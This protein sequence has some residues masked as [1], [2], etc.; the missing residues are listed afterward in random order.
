VST[1]TPEQVRARIAAQASVEPVAPVQAV[2]AP[3]V[4]SASGL[5]ERALAVAVGLAEGLSVRA[6]S[7]RSGIHRSSVGRISR[8][9]DVRQRAAAE[10]RLAG[11]PEPPSEPTEEERAEQVRAANAE[12][13]RKHR[14]R[15][16]SAEPEETT[17][18]TRGG[19]GGRVL[20]VI[21]DPWGDH[22]APQVIA[23]EREGPH[24]VRES[25]WRNAPREEQPVNATVVTPT[26]QFGYDP[27]DLADI[28]RIV[29]LLDGDPALAAY[30]DADLRATLASVQPG[31]TFV[32]EP[33]P[34]YAVT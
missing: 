23:F 30:S 7:E 5:D 16:R 6:I 17:R 8:R 15:V 33:A 9:E 20:G 1:P 32:I 25:E 28:H 29:R 22:G 14:E 19:S 2:A 3:V 34:E 10:R 21:F 13:Q 18:S 11:A 24:Q 26:G 27:T 31:S 4:R 12:R